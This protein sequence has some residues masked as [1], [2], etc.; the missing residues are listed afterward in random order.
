MHLVRALEIGELGADGLGGRPQHD[1]KRGLSAKAADRERDLEHVLDPLEDR[2]WLCRPNC[3]GADT[4]DG[5]GDFGLA[6]Q[7]SKG[8]DDGHNF[9]ADGDGRREEDDVIIYAVLDVVAKLSL[10]SRCTDRTVTS[11]GVEGSVTTS[12]SHPLAFSVLTNV[13]LLAQLSKMSTRG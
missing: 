9:G 2:H 4:D 5:E 8:G 1:Q 3:V 7:K 11:R 10:Y 13:T 12:I 6:C